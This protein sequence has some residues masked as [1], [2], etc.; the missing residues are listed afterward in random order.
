MVYIPETDEERQEREQLLAPSAGGQVISEAPAGVS[1]STGTPQQQ[2]TGGGA[3]GGAGG[4][5]FSKYIS[6]N[7]PG[8]QRLA[9]Q[10]AE[11]VGR[12][13]GE[14]RGAVSQA[15]Q[16]FGQQVQ[17]QQVDLPQNLLASLRTDP[18]QITQTPEALESFLRA[19][20]A[21]YTGPRT[22]QET[23][24]YQPALKEVREAQSARERTAT[25][26]GL[27]TL[28]QERAG[29]RPISP[30]TLR[31][32][33]AL[34]Q[35]TPAAQQRLAAARAGAQGLGGL[36]TG[37]EQQAQQRAEQIAATNLATQQ[38]T[39][40]AL[41]Q[42]QTGF[43][44][45]LEEEA[46]RRREAADLAYSRALGEL[47]GVRTGHGEYTGT[48][49]PE[50][51][52]DIGLTPEQFDLMR[53]LTGGIEK[54]G[55]AWYDQQTGEPVYHAGYTGIPQF[56]DLLRYQQF[57]SPGDVTLNTI[58]TQEDLARQEALNQLA[59]SPDVVITDP[60]RLGTAPADVV[61]DFDTAQYLN[62]LAFLGNLGTQSLFN[63]LNARERGSKRGGG[64]L[65]GLLDALGLYGGP[66]GDVARLIG[67]GGGGEEGGTYTAPLEPV[68]GADRFLQP[69][70]F[71]AQANRL[72]GYTGPVGFLGAGE[73]PELIDPQTG[74]PVPIMNPYTIQGWH[75]APAIDPELFRQLV[76]LTAQQGAV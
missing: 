32:D 14:A 43:R 31:F 51:L 1:A 3:Q 46:A 75:M 40:G 7:L 15:T 58:A 72:S 64:F 63:V 52:A 39:R 65:G 66:A 27:R 25:P 13:A 76:E 61:P 57:L 34:L 9:G 56:P 10:L 8:T 47:G 48:V 22:L 62:N 70:D 26:E 54:H 45:Q 16:Q 74:E 4:I 38:A 44:T 69:E 29:A 36:L 6:Q 12:E 59:I 5:D 28:L 2:A 24:F 42:A 49:S 35:S 11:R 50:T 19:R 68:T 37:A 18:T 55:V 30:G 53:Q 21:T 71:L 23:E 67:A 33:L 60:S 20:D 17:G 41:G 73:V